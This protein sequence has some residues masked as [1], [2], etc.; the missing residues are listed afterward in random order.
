MN[1]IGLP[2]GFIANPEWL[3]AIAKACRHTVG[4]INATYGDSPENMSREEIA[5]L[6]IASAYLYL[7]NEININEII[8]ENVIWH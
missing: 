6:N 5:Q 7:Y 3:Q 8:P 2:D 4:L 1:E